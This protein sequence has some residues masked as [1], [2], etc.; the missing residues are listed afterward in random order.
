MELMTVVQIS[1]PHRIYRAVITDRSK[2]SQIFCI[3]APILFVCRGKRGVSDDAGDGFFLDTRFLR[4]SAEGMAEK[5]WYD[6]TVIVLLA[7]FCVAFFAPLPEGE[8]I[9]FC[10]HIFWYS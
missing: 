8:G 1:L 9:L 2:S 4:Q 10:Y 3:Q 6:I 5:V 7:A